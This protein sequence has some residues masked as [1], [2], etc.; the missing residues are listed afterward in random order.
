MNPVSPRVPMEVN[1]S[2][3]ACYGGY[4]GIALKLEGGTLLALAAVFRA[5]AA[6]AAAFSASFFATRNA[7]L[8]FVLGAMMGPMM[9]L[10]RGF[11]LVVTAGVLVEVDGGSVGVAV[12]LVGL[13]GGRTASTEEARLPIAY[14]DGEALTEAWEAGR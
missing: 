5:A 8:L 2:K 11:G 9:L 12:Q 13:D 4:A 10:G 1:E 7:A 6:A 14:F 3:F